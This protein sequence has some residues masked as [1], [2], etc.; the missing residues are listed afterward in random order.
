MTK[1]ETT[2]KRDPTLIVSSC[3]GC[4]DSTICNTDEIYDC[5]CGFHTMDN[6]KCLCSIYFDENGTVIYYDPEAFE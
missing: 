5:K 4:E 6:E 1:K 3:E 2:I